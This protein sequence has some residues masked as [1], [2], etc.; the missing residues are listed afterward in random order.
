[1]ARMFE[2]EAKRLSILL[3]LHFPPGNAGE[4][5]HFVKAQP[6]TPR[7]PTSA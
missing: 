4:R 7:Y 6:K 1:M 3:I 2:F 5:Q